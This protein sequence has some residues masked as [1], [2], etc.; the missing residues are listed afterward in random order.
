MNYLEII[1]F[2][3][4]LL[5]LQETKNEH[6]IYI[7]NFYFIDFNAK[8]MLFKYKN[9]EWWTEY[10]DYDETVNCNTYSF[11]LYNNFNIF[12]KYY[13]KNHIELVTYLLNI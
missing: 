6:N 4:N 12:E 13:F 11:I 8:T 1:Y 5:D 2:I 10:L 3:A 7:D 9:K